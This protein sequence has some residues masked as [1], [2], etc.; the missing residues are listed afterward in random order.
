MWLANK[1]L[2]TLEKLHRAGFACLFEPGEQIA[3]GFADLGYE[4]FLMLSENKII[5][6]Q[7][8]KPS[9]LPE[10][11][12]HHFFSV[13]S[14]EKLAAELDCRDVQIVKIFPVGHVRWG[15]QVKAKDQ[16]SLEAATIVELLAEV[17][18]KELSRC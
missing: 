10:D 3:R 14:A 13:P 7:S 18:I 6:L 2:G 9:E 17:M 12:R 8:G 15:V 16:Y 4:Q 1:T 11:H 5:S